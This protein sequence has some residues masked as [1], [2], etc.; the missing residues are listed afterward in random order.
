[1]V[2]RLLGSCLVVGTNKPHDPLVSDSVSSEQN[3]Q[4]DLQPFI[5]NGE[6]QA[7]TCPAFTEVRKVL[8]APICAS[9]EEAWQT[10][11][12]QQY[13][14]HASINIMALIGKIRPL[15]LSVPISLL[16]TRRS[17]DESGGRTAVNLSRLTTQSV[18]L[19]QQ[20]SS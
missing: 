15:R 3:S 4:G 10:R 1:M 11:S 16:H 2:G 18:E 13:F 12:R 9:Q 20:Q 19:K 14:P 5:R 8:S 17:A 6:I 7:Q